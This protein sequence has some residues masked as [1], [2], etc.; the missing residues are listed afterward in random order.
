MSLPL[1]RVVFAIAGLYDLVIGAAFLIAGREIFDAS[2]VPHPNHWAY[3]QFAA[4]LLIVFGTM[5]FAVA[6]DPIGNRNLMPYGLLLKASYSGLVAYYWITTDCPMLFKP[7]AV[8]DAVMFVLF[9]VAYFQGL[10]SRD[11]A[12]AAA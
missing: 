3:V 1:V 11:P 10:A 4:L 9:L 8:I 12:R 7:F 2:G 6:Y 5:F